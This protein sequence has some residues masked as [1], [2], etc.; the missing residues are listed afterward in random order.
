M[1][2]CCEAF[3]MEMGSAS[4]VTRGRMTTG[5]AKGSYP[6]LMMVQGMSSELSEWSWTLQSKWVSLSGDKRAR[7][8]RSIA[9]QEMAQAV[10]FQ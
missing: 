4:P 8:R 2:H 5:Q 6:G 1:D 7:A 3:E 10:R 9:E